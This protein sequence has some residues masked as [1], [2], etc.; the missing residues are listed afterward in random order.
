MAIIA[1]FGLEKIEFGAIAAD[2]GVSAAFSQWGVTP[3]DET[4][5]FTVGKPDIKEFR[6]IENDD[7]EFVFESKKGTAKFEGSMF[8]V[9]SATLAKALGGTVAAGVYSSPSESFSLEQ[10]VKAT[11]LTGNVITAVRCK[12]VFW[13]TWNF[14]KDAIAKLS[15]EATVLKPTKAATPSWSIADPVAV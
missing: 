4:A 14:K 1:G 11:T 9:S 5:Q 12:V 2:G 13:I 15:Y 10:S 3:D 7:P 8:D 6:S